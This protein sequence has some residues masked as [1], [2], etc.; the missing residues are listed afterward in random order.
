MITAIQTPIHLEST[1]CVEEFSRLCGRIRQHPRERRLTSI[2]PERESE[3]VCGRRGRR[4]ASLDPHYKQRSTN[5]SIELEHA[6]SSHRSSG[7]NT[8]ADLVI[9]ILSNL[10]VFGDDEISAK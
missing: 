7:N 3:V 4:P 2:F 9:Q 1:S 10:S 8:G 5:F 6:T